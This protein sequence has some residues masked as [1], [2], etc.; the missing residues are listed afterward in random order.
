[1]AVD[2][3]GFW[4]NAFGL[5]LCADGTTPALPPFLLPLANQILAAGKSALLLQAHA[6]WRRGAAD[7]AAA[8]AAAG[9][10]S[11]AAP[12]RRLD[13]E[14]P[15]KRRLS[16]FG[17]LGYALADGRGRGDGREAA[18]ARAPY[19]PLPPPAPLETWASSDVRALQRLATEATEGEEEAAEPLPLHQH[20]LRS[21]REQLEEAAQSP[22]PTGAASAAAA[23]AVKQAQAQAAPGGVTGAA[24]TAGGI[25]GRS[26]GG[27]CDGHGDGASGGEHEVLAGWL[28]ATACDAHRLLLDPPDELPPLPAVPASPPVPP[29]AV[30]Q[31]PTPAF[32][33][34]SAGGSVAISGPGPI[35]GAEGC[36]GLS[37][38]DRMRAAS[39]ARVAAAAVEPLD[40]LPQLLVSPAVLPAVELEAAQQQRQ[41]EGG[42]SA[43][44]ARLHPPSPEFESSVWAQWYERTA[45]ALSTQLQLIHG[46]GGGDNNSRQSRRRQRQQQLASCGVPLALEPFE[47]GVSAATQVWRRT[48]AGTLA[49]PNTANAPD[50]NLAMAVPLPTPPA[51]ASEAPPLGVLLQ[52]ALLRPVADA[53][54]AAGGRLCAALLRQVR[55]RRRGRGRACDSSVPKALPENGTPTPPP[56][57]PPTKNATHTQGLLSQLAV[58]RETFLLGSPLLEPFVASLLRRIRHASTAAA[59]ADGPCSCSRPL[60][61]AAEHPTPARPPTTPLPAFL[62]GPATHAARVAASTASASSS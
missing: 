61:P 25:S 41:A 47:P 16:E 37:I 59:A 17:A 19:A 15:S 18:A 27:G 29:G 5:R 23:L 14:S 9:A 6:A 60:L 12:T 57:P 13:L 21:L 40:A 4:T 11:A 7:G 56:P 36:L 53:A 34:C 50:S 54:E 1:M 55:T 28:A 32:A 43:T 39:S 8:C 35:G 22:A 62:R 3:T 44:G 45:A 33:G 49:A 2:S 38:G 24:A 20:L 42:C 46:G 26:D 10:P 31:A 48:A 51:L 30:I 52:R 58:L